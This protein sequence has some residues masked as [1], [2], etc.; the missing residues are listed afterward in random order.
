[1]CTAATYSANNF[2]F[3]RTLDNDCS[4]NEE[5]VITPRRYAFDMKFG[6]PL[7]THFA[8]VGMAHVESGR[9]L[10]YDAVNEHGLCMAGLNFVG[11]AVYSDRCK[12]GMDNIAQ[13]DLMPRILGTCATA[14]QA[15]KLLARA[16]VTNTPF[17][18]KL[19][20]AE[21]HWIIADSREA[22]T[23]ESTA[24]GLHVYDNPV[25]ILTNNPTFPE[26]M[27]ALNNY[28]SLSPKQPHN[29][30]CSDLPLRTY[31]NGMG[32]LGLPGDL[33]SQ[34]R[35]VRA[36]FTKTNA[37]LC[38]CEE[39]NVTQFFHILGSV[40]QTRGC[41]IMDNGGEEITL[42]TSCCNAD[43]GIYYYTSYYNSGITAVDM[44]RV[45]LDGC[46]IVRY[47]L[48]NDP[49]IKYQN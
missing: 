16:N 27:F 23:V 25:G 12:D 30:F 31:S 33:S 17:D 41:C 36:A 43:K 22:F 8:I 35:F 45:D 32:A 39:K 14:E 44:H 20:V 42:Y 15:K 6:R 1:M 38:D 48:V 9:P 13:C 18:D 21:L 19:H 46:A 10:Y 3:G 24:S 26:Q 2:Y 49:S 7:N 28:M 37:A 11:N 29:E 40:S 4:Y 34:S 5:V 47:K